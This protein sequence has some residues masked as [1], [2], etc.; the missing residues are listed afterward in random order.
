M[1]YEDDVSANTNAA[2]DTTSI[3]FYVKSPTLVI[4]TEPNDTFQGIDYDEDDQLISVET[5]PN[6]NEMLV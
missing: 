1:N 5:E 6:I 4:D 3:F 2:Y